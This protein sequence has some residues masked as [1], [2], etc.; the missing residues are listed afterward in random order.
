MPASRLYILRIA[1]L[2]IILFLTA[3]CGSFSPYKRTVDQAQNTSVPDTTSVPIDTSLDQDIRTRH[4]EEKINLLEHRLVLL[5]KKFNEQPKPE[6][7]KPDPTKPEPTK[8]QISQTLSPPLPN[9]KGLLRLQKQR[10]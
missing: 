3:A 10:R 1:L 8:K 2:C 6:P 7:P 4:L 5:E 9:P